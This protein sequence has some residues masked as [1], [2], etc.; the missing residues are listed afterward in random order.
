[1]VFSET[2]GPHASMTVQEV[3]AAAAVLAQALSAAVQQFET[4][5]GTIVHSLPVIPAE[6]KTP[7]SVRVKVQIPG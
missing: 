6:G 5:T 4:Q 3:Q 1:M 2:K 7:A